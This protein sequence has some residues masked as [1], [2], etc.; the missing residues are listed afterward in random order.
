MIC[1]EELD[2]KFKKLGKEIREQSKLSDEA[3]E[4]IIAKLDEELKKK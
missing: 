2:A 1:D 3:K 4:R